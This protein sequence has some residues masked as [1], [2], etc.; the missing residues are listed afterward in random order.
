MKKSLRLS[1][2]F[3]GLL[4][5]TMPVKA[6]TDVTST[7]LTNAGFNETCNYLATDAAANLGS[8]N[9]GANIK[10]VTGWTK[11]TIGDNSAAASYE[12]GYAGTLNISGSTGYIPAA[13]PNAETGA[14]QGALGLSAAWGA[15]L[16]YY[17]D[18]TLPAGKYIIYSQSINKGPNAADATRFGWVPSSGSS[19]LATRTSF[20]LNEWVKDSVIVTLAEQTTGKIQVGIAAPNA[21]SGSVGRIF[22]DN[23]KIVV[24]PVSKTVLKTLIDSAT[25]IVND[26]KPVVSTSTVYADLTSTISA[27]NAV[28][29]SATATLTDVAVSEGTLQ[30]G[31]AAVYDAI[32]LKSRI[33]SWTVLPYDATASIANNSFETALTGWTN[34]GMVTQTN[35]S[36]GAFKNGTTYAEKWMASPGTLTNLKIS[37]IVK[38]VPNGIYKITMAGQAIQ[39][40]NPAAYPGGAYVFANADSTEVFILGDYEVLTK[41]TNNQINLGFV[42]KTTGNWV[43]IDNFRLS[44]ISDGSPYTV[45]TPAAL[46]FTPSVKEKTFNV[47][48]DNFDADLTLSTSSNFSLSKSTLTPAEIKAGVDVT[49]TALATAEVAADSIVLTSGS[50]TS[51]VYASLKETAIGVSNYGFFFDQSLTPSKTLTVSGD[52]FG[53]VALTAPEGISLTATSV[54]AAEALAGKAIDVLWNETTLVNDKYIYLTSG[55]KTDSVIVFAVKNSIISAWDANDSIG[56]G[57]KLTDWGWSHTLADGVTAGAAS[58]G[59]FNGGGTRLVTVANAAHTYKGKPLAG[60]RTAYL[61]TWGN[62]ATNAFN[63]AVELEADKQYA[64]RGLAGWHNNETNP[65]FTI[66]VNTAKANTGDTLAI[67]AVECTVKQQARDYGFTFVPTT[68]GVHF[69]TV[70][71]SAINDAMCGVSFLAIYPVSQSGTTSTS[72]IESTDVQ[73][74]PTVARGNLTV[75]L[76]GNAA[77]V[78]VYSVSGKMVFNKQTTSDINLNL[79]AEG[80]YIVKVSGENVN[81]TVKVL[82]LK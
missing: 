74:F 37:Q 17:Q 21:G 25:V 4:T 11:G 80:M 53:D 52:L 24:P 60:H 54:T 15:T 30:S 26:P 61:R 8:A 3:L 2:L 23:V 38:N 46:A 19:V 45:L 66:A 22:I 16:T 62:P 78:Q 7:Y 71:S 79:A 42:V 9:A 27:A 44:Y 67:Q 49:V 65:I 39:Q 63:L 73:V 6:Q 70:T 20:P 51:K 75:K 13:G 35:T 31:I 47:K 43:A 57:T 40:T 1:G 14:G 59:D 81:K 32:Q 56:T 18:V 82:N 55:S 69:L 68:T 36:M 29:T 5:L 12:Y 10:V 34:S 72:A 64:F 76:N 77:N 41:V 58:F 28:F 33:D 48:G 50:Y